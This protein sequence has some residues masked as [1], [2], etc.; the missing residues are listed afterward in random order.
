[1]FADTPSKWTL[2]V[3]MMQPNWLSPLVCVEKLARLFLVH[4]RLKDTGALCTHP[5][6]PVIVLYVHSS[7]KNV[8]VVLSVPVNRFDVRPA[9]GMLPVPVFCVY[10]VPSSGS[11]NV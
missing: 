9:L 11:G 6:R 2:L 10:L 4:V 3:M 8:V 5:I 1:M 7:T